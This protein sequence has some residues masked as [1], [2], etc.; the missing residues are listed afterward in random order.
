MAGLALERRKKREVI[1]VDVKE[2]V[3]KLSEIWAE[4]RNSN[5]VPSDH[6]ARAILAAAVLAEVA[7]DRR[8]NRIS[9]ERRGEGKG[10]KPMTQ[11]QHDF[12][13]KYKVTHEHN[14]TLSQ[15]SRAIDEK[16]A[17]WKGE[18]GDK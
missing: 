14:W 3:G 18:G 2:Y 1:E 8:M 9:E 4:F 17:Q 5:A 15:A 7:K 10:D 11:R 12:L 13:D 6:Q 16:I